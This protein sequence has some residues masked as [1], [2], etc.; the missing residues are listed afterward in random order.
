MLGKK[1]KWDDMLKGILDVKGLP[2]P[3]KSQYYLPCDGY[4]SVTDLV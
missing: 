1:G 4:V 3:S 2:D